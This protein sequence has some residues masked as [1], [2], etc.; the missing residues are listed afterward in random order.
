MADAKTN[1]KDPKV[2]AQGAAKDQRSGQPKGD[3]SPAEGKPVATAPARLREIYKNEIV[4][5]LTKQFGYKSVMQV[6]RVT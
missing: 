6:A 1:T 5:A 4:P 3:D 2:K